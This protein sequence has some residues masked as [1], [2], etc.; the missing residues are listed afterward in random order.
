V[1]RIESK[2]GFKEIIAFPQK[3]STPALLDV[4]RRTWIERTRKTTIL[5]FPLNTSYTSYISLVHGGI[6]AAL[7]DKGCAKYCNQGALTLY[8]LTKTLNIEFKKLSP[9]GE[10][11]IAKVSTSRLFPLIISKSRKVRVAYKVSVL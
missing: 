2:P 6:L 11:F 10:I 1:K 9:I 4:G 3:L 7:V 5:I 8:P